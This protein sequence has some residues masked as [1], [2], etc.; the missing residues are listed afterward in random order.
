MRYK[1]GQSAYRMG[2][3]CYDDCGAG[4]TRHLSQ[5]FISIEKERIYRGQRKNGIIAVK[6]RTDSLQLKDCNEKERIYCN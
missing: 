2:K 6:E 5:S 1:S 3:V 4:N